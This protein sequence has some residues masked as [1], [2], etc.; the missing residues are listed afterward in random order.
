MTGYFRRLAGRTGLGRIAAPAAPPALWAVLERE[1]VVEVSAPA[2]SPV[3]AGIGQEL[4]AVVLPGV[5]AASVPLPERRTANDD[6]AAP[7]TKPPP[8]P[9]APA[10]AV[11]APG[12]RP[13]VQ[14]VPPR[15]RQR[16]MPPDPAAAIPPDPAASDRLLPPDPAAPGGIGPAP[17]SDRAERA[18]SDPVRPRPSDRGPAASVAARG[19][20]EQPSP[21]SAPRRAEPAAVQ[22]RA[23]VRAVPLPERPARM[24]GPPTRPIEQAPSLHIG[25]I[26]V[27]VRAPQPPPPPAEAA[28][29]PRSPRAPVALRRFHLRDW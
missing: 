15:L 5:P 14:S 17:P 7:A 11:P 12:L 9:P 8:E 23:A 16:P 4:P 25:S 3:T 28:P 20:E 24:P 27:E 19:T 10:P 2:P 1:E 18:L 6:A 13:P 29:A 22:D 21:P 26:R